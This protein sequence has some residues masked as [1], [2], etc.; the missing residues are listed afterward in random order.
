MFFTDIF[1]YLSCFNL[2]ETNVTQS[3]RPMNGVYNARLLLGKN[4][5]ENGV[6]TL[7]TSQMFSVH[8]EPEKSV[9]K[10]QSPYRSFWICV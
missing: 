6:F 4:K 5:F 3:M 9:K 2:F 1:P 8:T 7:K 10:L